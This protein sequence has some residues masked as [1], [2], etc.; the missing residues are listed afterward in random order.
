MKMTQINLGRPVHDWT[1]KAA[2]G[3][4]L[5]CIVKTPEGEVSRPWEI[6]RL[7]VEQHGS[8]NLNQFLALEGGL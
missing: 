1:V 2:D 8:I 7:F 4:V 3:A 5:H 6:V